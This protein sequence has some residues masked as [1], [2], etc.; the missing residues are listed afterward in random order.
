MTRVARTPSQVVEDYLKVIYSHTEW[1]D[2]P[3]TPKRLGERL[4]LAPSSVTETVKRLMAQGL[5]EHPRY[6][7]IALTAAGEAEALRMVRRHRL[8]ETW[9]VR[10]YGYGWDEVHDEAEVLEHALSD[11]M[12]DLIDARLGH[13]A[14]DPHGDPIP[15][16]AG[17]VPAT[18]GL[19]LAEL[20][21]GVSGAVVRISDEDPAVLRELADRGVGLD[22]SVRAGD[23]SSGAE[24]AIWV[25][26]AGAE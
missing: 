1:Q 15:D 22:S 26:V 12:L 19:L 8:V 17:A 9:L 25:V 20:T 23:L 18:S 21:R 16:A 6:G 24:N 11:R 7:A 10:E 3:I 4:G 13:P 5:V 14:R 2:E